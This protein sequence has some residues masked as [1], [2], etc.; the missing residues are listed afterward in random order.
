MDIHVTLFIQFMIDDIKQH[1]PVFIQ[2][3]YH[4]F[5]GKLLPVG[6]LMQFQLFNGIVIVTQ[7]GGI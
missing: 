2:Q 7:S 3:S 1:I 6:R 5:P 4:L